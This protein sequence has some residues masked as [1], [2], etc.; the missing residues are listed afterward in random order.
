MA[1]TTLWQARQRVSAAAWN[2]LLRQG[3][4]HATDAASMALITGAV[5]KDMCFR[6]D[7]NS[8]YMYDGTTWNL[9]IDLDEVG[10]LGRP[11]YPFHNR[12]GVA[13]GNFY[14]NNEDTTTQGTARI[15]YRLQDQ[16]GADILEIARIN[17]VVAG[18]ITNRVTDITIPF[19]NSQLNINPPVLNLNAARINL[20]PTTFSVANTLIG[21]NQVVVGTAANGI[22]VRA[23]NFL[24]LAG[25]P[26]CVC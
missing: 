20:Q 21:N 12:A 11:Y 4:V 10:S 7:V 6:E 3:L 22:E 14:L 15:Q 19:R 24:D 16:L 18:S 1:N 8:I 9:L 5:D 2:A 17:T 23:L 13:Q 25:T 26:E